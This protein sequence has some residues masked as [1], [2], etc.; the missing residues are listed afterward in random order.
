MCANETRYKWNYKTKKDLS[1]GFCEARTA[2]FYT[3]PPSEKK[4]QQALENQNQ[5]G[6]AESTRPASCEHEP[7]SARGTHKKAVLIVLLYIRTAL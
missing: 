5:K 6:T 7:G 2:K 4:K 1:A 3:E